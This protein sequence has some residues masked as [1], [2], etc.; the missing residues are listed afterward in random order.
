M[1]YGVLFFCCL[2]CGPWHLAYEHNHLGSAVSGSKADLIDK[3]RNGA[4]VRVMLIRSN[5]DNPY[6]TSVQNAYVVGNELCGQALFH[7]SKANY[8]QFQVI[9][10][11]GLSHYNYGIMYHASAEH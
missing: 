7:V 6:V 5:S 11:C 8:K 1:I 4:N 2:D 9:L 10:T 3:V